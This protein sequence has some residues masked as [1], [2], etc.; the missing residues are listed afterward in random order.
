M[1]SYVKFMTHCP[2]EYVS[3][4]RELL[5]YEAKCPY[6]CLLERDSVGALVRN[7]MPSPLH[8]SRQ[9]EWPWA[10]LES[11]IR[12][13]DLC[14]EV[15]GSWTVLKHAIAKRCWE[16][17]CLETNTDEDMS[18]ALHTCYVIG[19]RIQFVLGDVRA[20]P[21]PDNWFDRVFCISV[22][23]HI[24]E[25]HVGEGRLLAV[26]EMIRV[27]KPG[28]VLMLT[29]DVITERGKGSQCEGLEGDEVREILGLMNLKAE[30]GPASL[31]EVGGS[32]VVVVMVRYVK[33]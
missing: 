6:S 29:F 23:E 28:G 9:T 21:W 8:W 19:S 5:A 12:P 33:E 10:I 7:L 14:L 1:N 16:L 30:K 20:C 2:E 24:Y 32:Q 15:G 26:K 22:L 25:R 18:K 4:V 11:N 27:L 13:L 31:G 17:T 3:T